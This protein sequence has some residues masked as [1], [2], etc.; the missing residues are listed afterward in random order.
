MG[1][2]CLGVGHPLLVGRSFDVCIVDEAGQI[3]IPAVLGCLMLAR[4]FCLVGDHFQLPPLVQNAQA[5]AEGLSCSLFKRLCEAHPQVC[6]ATSLLGS[7]NDRSLVTAAQTF[8]PDGYIS[9]HVQLPPAWDSYNCIVA[10]QRFIQGGV[11]SHL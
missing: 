11:L 5:A 2:T 6:R 9:A 8:A 3:T 1:C 7:P 4:S 10:L